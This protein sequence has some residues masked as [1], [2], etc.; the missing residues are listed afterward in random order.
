MLRKICGILASVMF[1]LPGLRS[2]LADDV[3]VSSCPTPC[4]RPPSASAHN[5]VVG[6]RTEPFPHYGLPGVALRSA[7]RGRVLVIDASMSNVTPSVPINFQMV[8][9]VTGGVPPDSLQSASVDCGGT[10]AVTPPATCS[11]TAHWW[12]DLDA[13]PELF[14]D[15]LAIALTVGTEYQGAQAPILA[16]TLSA[17]LEKK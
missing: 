5:Q 11:A 13:H 12:M 14:G 15:S 6:F 7:K 10:G 1:L 2:A 9:R 8:P 3:V 16:I 4:T 17:R